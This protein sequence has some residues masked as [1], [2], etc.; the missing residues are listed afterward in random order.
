M[1]STY[2]KIVAAALFCSTLA[3]HGC[4]PGD[5][6]D[7]SVRADDADDADDALVADDE[8]V[9]V[10]D[11]FAVEGP[12]PSGLYTDCLVNKR[13]CFWGQANYQGKPLIMLGEGDFAIK[14]FGVAIWS[15]RKR[16]KTYRVKLF[17]DPNY[18]GSCM[19]LGPD[20]KDVSVPK[21]PFPNGARSARRMEPSEGGCP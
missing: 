20:F 4:D 11:A 15:V 5:E 19:V 18:K 10:A 13:F 3:V 2:T 7:L 9:P 8:Q 21:L 14:D 6:E 1:R 12:D 16:E 17:S